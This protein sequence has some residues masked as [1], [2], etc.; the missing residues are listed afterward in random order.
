MHPA[1]VVGAKDADAFFGHDADIPRDPA[2]AVAAER[3]AEGIQV[4]EGL[5]QALAAHGVDAKGVHRPAEQARPDEEDVEQADGDGEDREGVE[6][7]VPPLGLEP[8]DEQVHH[9]HP[10]HADEGD[11]LETQIEEDHGQG[12]VG[13]PLPALFVE[14]IIEDH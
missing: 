4:G 12:K 10:E 11:A 13:D 5:V 3:R 2:D 14:G 1:E 9:K 6:H 8:G 7:E